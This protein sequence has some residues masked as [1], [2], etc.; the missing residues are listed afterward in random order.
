MQIYEVTTRLFSFIIRDMKSEELEDKEAIPF[1][2]IVVVVMLFLY[3]FTL[4]VNTELR[5]AP[6]LL[7]FSAGMALHTGLHWL[8]RRFSRKV[9]TAV[10]Y[11]SIQSLLAALLILYTGERILIPGLYLALL[12]EETGLFRGLKNVLIIVTVNV[13]LMILSI[14]ATGLAGVDWFLLA[15][16]VPMLLFVIIYVNLYSRQI[17]A[18]VEAQKLLEEL[19][20]TNRKLSESNE[21]VEE[22][23]REKERQRIARE[24]HDTLAQG[25]SGLIL[26]L[27]AAT[28]NLENGRT[29]KTTE[30]IRTSMEKARE[31]LAD[32]RGVIDDLRAQ[33]TGVT[34]LAGSIRAEIDALQQRSDISFTSSIGNLP[35]IQTETALHL[36]KIVT[37]ALGNCVEHSGAANVSL[38][39][40]LNDDHLYLEITDDGCGFEPDKV[41]SGHYGLI[42]IRERGPDSRR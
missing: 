27:E 29:E 24:L 19:E 12:G 25:L 2:I 4:Y 26:Q 36:M 23:T 3:L 15:G 38:L 41:G 16:A 18:R 20:L 28:A 39:L 31:T 33:P 6:G 42:G 35:F 22:L 30:I 8:F 11:F 13:A 37:E 21:R 32:A 9:K 40:R 34:G 17:E 10:I 5:A 14:V 7:F 1:F